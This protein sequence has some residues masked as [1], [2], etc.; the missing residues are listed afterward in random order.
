MIEVKNNY[1]ARIIFDF[2]IDR[3]LRKNFS[4][5][6]LL[7]NFPALKSQNSVVL[8]PNHFSWWDGFLIDWILKKET[9]HQIKIMMLE[10]QLKRFWFF[11]YLGA[12]SIEP[13]NPA[14]IKETVLYTRSLINKKGNG[15]VIYPQGEIEPYE[16]RP[17]QLKEGLKLILKPET[18]A[19][20]IPVGFKIHFMKEKL[21]SVLCRLGEPL[22]AN[23]IVNDFSLFKE[24][25][26]CNM[27]L[28]DESISD[29][30][31]VKDYFAKR[32]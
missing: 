27:N 4:H 1:L 15:I 30:I 17:L 21:P 23:T 8:T 7:N 22:H 6:Y 13:K 19:F 29:L 5:F 9:K 25:F 3:L 26:N 16:K 10:E 28:L 24:S 20:V 2:Y 32:S 11:N 12:Y 31:F 14:S 18:D